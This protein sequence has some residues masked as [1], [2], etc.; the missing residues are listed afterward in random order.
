MEHI[1]VGIDV[2]QVGDPSAVAVAETETREDGQHYIVR[3]LERLSLGLAYPAQADRLVAIL[4]AVRA[5]NTGARIVP[6]LDVTGVGLAMMDL[7]RDRGE[8]EVEGV[9]LTGSDNL[10]RKE[11]YR[12]SCGKSVLVSSLLVTVQGGRIHLPDTEDARALASELAHFRA[13]TTASGRTT[14]NARSGKHDDLLI[15]LGLCTL[16]LIAPD[17]RPAP[18]FA[19]LGVASIARG[20]GV[21]PHRSGLL[22]DSDDDD[23]KHKRRYTRRDFS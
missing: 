12:W 9:S 8:Y 13:E 4:E 17:T 6:V 15:A 1:Q 21:T 18:P 5:R 14:Y 20:W 23:L 11:P 3:H 16:P 22:P 7:L 10:H 2:G 19:A